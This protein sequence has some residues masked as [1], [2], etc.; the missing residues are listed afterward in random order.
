[1]TTPRLPSSGVAQPSA[2]S[3]HARDSSGPWDSASSSC[4]ARGGPG[5]RGAVGAGRVRG[6]GG[7]RCAGAR[8]SR[9]RVTATRLHDALQVAQDLRHAVPA[10]IRADTTGSGARK[11]RQGRWPRAQF[12]GGPASLTRRCVVRRPARQRAC[13][14]A[15]PTRRWPLPPLPHAAAPSRPAGAGAGRGVRAGRVGEVRRRP[16]SRDPAL[17]TRP[18]CA[19]PSAPG[20]FS[21]AF[22]GDPDPPGGPQGRRCAPAVSRGMP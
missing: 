10:E 1:M 8:G 3:Y 22:P 17:G 14:G 19:L 9:R 12:E 11:P 2:R 13:G 15:P 7:L 6:A 18:P 20:P 5:R 16:G 4:G 21:N